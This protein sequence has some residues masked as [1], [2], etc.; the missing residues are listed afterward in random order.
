MRKTTPKAAAADW[1]TDAGRALDAGQSVTPP[2]PTPAP[3]PRAVPVPE[4]R[5][6]KF[7]AT[8]DGSTDAL[9]TRLT[10]ELVAEVGRI[11]T[12]TDRERVRTGYAPSRADLLRALLEV[13]DDDPTVMTAV[14][15]QVQNRY[16]R[17]DS[18]T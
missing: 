14:C 5:T 10:G 9:F 4:Q 18:L 2:A 16:R 1:S 11:A 3:A 12:R 17:T 6:V 8:L 7:T 13:A 15:A